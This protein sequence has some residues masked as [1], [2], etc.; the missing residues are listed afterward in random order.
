[1]SMPAV[2]CQPRPLWLAATRRERPQQACPSLPARRLLPGRDHTRSALP[3]HARGKSRL[4]ARW[5]DILFQKTVRVLAD[6]ARPRIR[7][8]AALVV[9]GAGR[10]AALFAL[11]ALD[12]KALIIAAR[13]VDRGLQRRTARL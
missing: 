10:L 5:L 2:S 4:A 9:G 8:G 12:L 6:I 7:P 3:H 1:M 11:A 13:P